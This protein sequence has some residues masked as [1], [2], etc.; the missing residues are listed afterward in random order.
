MVRKL[1]LSVLL[2]F[3]F[4]VLSVAAQGDLAT[5]VRFGHFVADASNVDVFSTVNWF[6]KIMNLPG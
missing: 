6:S 4:N 5:E 3:A 1:V 2:V